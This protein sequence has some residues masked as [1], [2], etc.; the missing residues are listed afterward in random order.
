MPFNS[1][2]LAGQAG[3]GGFYNP[4][5]NGRGD[6]SLNPNASI[7]DINW[8]ATDAR[9]AF[10]IAA[11]GKIYLRKFPKSTGDASPDYTPLIR[12]SEIM[13]NLA[14]ALVRQNNTVDARAV[15]LLNAIRQRSDNTTTFTPADVASLLA[16]IATERRIELLGEG[17]RSIDIMR[18]GQ[19]F[20]AKDVAMA[21]S[22]SSSQYI[23]PIPSSERQ[24]NTLCEQNPGY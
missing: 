8:K 7:A 20:P 14:E 13:L 2:D 17:F 23:W 3:L 5:P 15:A 11:A 21:I 10:N 19:G 16:L 9:R 6:Y 18:L 4:G 24:Q 22:T 12:Y 1:G